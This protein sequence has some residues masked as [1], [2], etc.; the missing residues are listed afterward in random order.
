M[1]STDRLK[2]TPQEKRCIAAM[3][4][5]HPQTVDRY[6][7]GSPGRMTTRERIERAIIDLGLAHLLGADVTDPDAAKDLAR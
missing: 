2:P 4:A 6:F 3:S 7:A 5:S 1:S